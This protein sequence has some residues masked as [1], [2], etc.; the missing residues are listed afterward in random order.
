MQTTAHLTVYSPGFNGLTFTDK[1]RPSELTSGWLV[2]RSLPAPSTT[3]SLAKRC[4]IGASYFIDTA[5]GAAARVCPAA[6]FCSSGKECAQAAVAV[7][8][9][10]NRASRQAANSAK[11]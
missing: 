7:A 2:A 4:S 8:T 6:G 9:V 5:E 1:I 11:F 10:T 3:S